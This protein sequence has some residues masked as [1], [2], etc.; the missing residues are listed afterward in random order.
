FTVIIAFV[1]V[2]MAW[3]IYFFSGYVGEVSHGTLD[4]LQ[5]EVEALNR[6]LDAG[7]PGVAQL[8]NTRPHFRFD[9]SGRVVLDDATVTQFERDQNKVVR[10]L[11]FE[12]PFFV[13]VVMTGLFIIARSLRVER[14]L[15]QRQ[16]NFLDAVGHEYKTP[17]GSLRLMVE[18]LQLRQVTPEKL[19]EY[20][21]TMGSEIDRLEQTAQQVLATARLE[22]DAPHL[23]MEPHE[24]G[25]LVTELVE[26]ALPSL[27]GRGGDVRLHKSEEP[28]FVTADRG[29]MAVLLENL[30]DNAVKYTPGPHKLVEVHVRRD[31]SA[32]LV[33]VD[34]RGVG[35]PEKERRLV[36]DRFYR[37][38]NE[39][40]R[41]SPGVGLGL[42]LVKRAAESLGGTVD[43]EARPGGG[44]RASV[45]LPLL[46]PVTEEAE[47]PVTDA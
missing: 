43:I 2:Q 4:S 47:R 9:S 13:L 26:G 20:L 35:I 38:G 27:A 45:W 46:V 16:Q 19:Q 22:T 39:L 3:W 24:L 8:L 36:F 21:S 15:K 44:T 17:L 32:A 28:L 5:R 23:A 29:L 11:A 37:V 6:M 34:D 12:G 31:G 7:D 41:T 25:A 40:T 14:E 30:L 33:E 18:T 42:Y 1:T 10:M